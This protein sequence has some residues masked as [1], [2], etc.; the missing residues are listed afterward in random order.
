[1]TEITM[2]LKSTDQIVELEGGGKARLW[3]G[4]TDAGRCGVLVV[5]IGS[6]DPQV[7]D[8]LRAVELMEIPPPLSEA[9]FHR[10]MVA[11]GES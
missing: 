6:A 9:T 3:I 4:Y 2:T 10:A 7:K 8:Y 5:G 11:Q 1:M